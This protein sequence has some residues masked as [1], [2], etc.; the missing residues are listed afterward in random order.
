MVVADVRDEGNEEEVLKEGARGDVVGLRVGAAVLV[1]FDVGGLEV[2]K[3]GVAERVF[4]GM[5]EAVDSKVG[6]TDGLKVG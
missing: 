2:L 5:R 6:I 1:G 4:E 3:E